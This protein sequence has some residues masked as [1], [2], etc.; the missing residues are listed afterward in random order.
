MILGN[1]TSKKQCQKDEGEYPRIEP[2]LSYGHGRD[3]PRGR[4]SSLIGGSH[5][6]DVVITGDNGTIDG[7]GSLWWD[8]FHQGKLAS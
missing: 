4:F 2:L 8:K 3:G 1:V 5:L 7:Q 6:A